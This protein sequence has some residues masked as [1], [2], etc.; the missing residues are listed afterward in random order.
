MQQEIRPEDFIVTEQDGTRRI[1]HDVVESYGLFNLPKAIMR[2]ALMIY[3]D[4]AA[5]EGRQS[6]AAVR[7][8]IGLAASISK[9]PKQVAI[10][11][12][13]GLA[14]RRNM[15]MLRRYSR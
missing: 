6:A 12:T 9:F 2:S 1:N 7:T 10:N 14:Y 4:N 8:F 5:R 3:Y 15:K 11:F 13:R